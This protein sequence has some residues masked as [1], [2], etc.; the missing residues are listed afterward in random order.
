MGLIHLIRHETN[1]TIEFVMA[2]G[3]IGLGIWFHLSETEWCFIFLCIG[4]VLGAEGLNT[5][6]E[7]LCDHVT[8]ERHESIRIVKDVAAGAVLIVGIMVI[9]VGLVIFG[10]KILE[11]L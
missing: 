8:T 1:A 11:L 6:V 7:K 2:L 4:A 10:P 5:A 9:C 3:F